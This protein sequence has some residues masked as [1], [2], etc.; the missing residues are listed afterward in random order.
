MD[1]T[2]R[3][4]EAE[5]RFRTLLADAGIGP[6]DAV[7]YGYTCVR[8]FWSGPKVCVVVDLDEPSCAHPGAAC[9]G[10]TGSPDDGRGSEYF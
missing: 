2:P 1:I 6:P 3:H 8:F 7:E 9:S 10:R 4:E 5:A